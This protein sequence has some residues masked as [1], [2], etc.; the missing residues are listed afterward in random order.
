MGIE[1]VYIG[2]GIEISDET[3]AKHLNINMNELEYY[4]NNHKIWD[5]QLTLLK[6]SNCF[7]ESEDYVS[8]CYFGVFI[9]LADEWNAT[10]ITSWEINQI[11]Q[12]SSH[13]FNDKCFDE[14]HKTPQ[15]MI[16]VIGC[17]CCS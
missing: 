3:L 6:R 12:L 2:C 15:R 9:E 10:M 17:P 16:I 4:I 11:A 8:T 5:M 14:L 1:G 13:P 7:N